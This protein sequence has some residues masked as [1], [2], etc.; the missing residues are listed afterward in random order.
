M[1]L[2][3]S[4]W[5]GGL[6]TLVGCDRQY[7]SCSGGNA[8]ADGVVDTSGDVPVFDWEFGTAY[9][10]SVYEMDGNDFGKS[11]WHIQCGGD[12]LDND[13]ELEENVCIE[14]PIAYGDRIDSAYFD[15]VNFTPPKPLEAGAPYQLILATLIEDDGPR[16]EPN[17]PVMAEIQSWTPDREDKRCGSG[18]T[19]EVDFVLD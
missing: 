7:G 15:D 2:R 3:W 16:I 18:F 10:L 17:N 8:P 13:E 1:M 12:N 9:A 4:V 14:T 5:A 19:A 6:A 11:M